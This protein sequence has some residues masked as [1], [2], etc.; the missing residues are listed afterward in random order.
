MLSR[1]HPQLERMMASFRVKPP[2]SHHDQENYAYL[3]ETCSILRQRLQSVISEFVLDGVLV[4]RCARRSTKQRGG[5]WASTRTVSRAGKLQAPP[6]CRLTLFLASGRPCCRS[7][8]SSVQG[9]GRRGELRLLMCRINAVVP[10]AT[11]STSL[12]IDGFLNQREAPN[13]SSPVPQ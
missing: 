8:A 4:S 12:D 5:G 2:W 7:K 6:L 13:I 11:R 1:D 10:E 9:S 3:A